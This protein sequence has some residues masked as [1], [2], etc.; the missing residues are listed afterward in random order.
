MSTKTIR[1][2]VK[3]EPFNPLGQK[4]L[5]IPIC[6]GVEQMMYNFGDLH[7]TNYGVSKDGNITVA[8]QGRIKFDFEKNELLIFVWEEE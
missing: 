1:L 2:K 5:V 4:S 3:K 8:I 6:M 7:P